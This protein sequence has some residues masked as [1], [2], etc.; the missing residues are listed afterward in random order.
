MY[1]PV[2]K[3]ISEKFNKAVKKLY[4][5]Y[6]NNVMKVFTPN[7]GIYVQGNSNAYAETIVFPEW[8]IWNRIFIFTRVDKSSN[9]TAV[10]IMSQADVFQN[11]Y[12]ITNNKNPLVNF[13]Q[14]RYSNLD[15]YRCDLL[16]KLTEEHFQNK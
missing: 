15:K 1:F 2:P 10:Y 16:L 14:L 6:R 4:L 13:R 8:K 9:L 12:I 3:K 5:D 7:E 11:S